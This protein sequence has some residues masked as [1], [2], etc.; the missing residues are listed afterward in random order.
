MN[1]RRLRLVWILSLILFAGLSFIPATYAQNSTIYW[2]PVEQNINQGLTRFLERSFAEA[3][4]VNAS[5]IVIEMDTLGGEVDSALEIGR[6]IRESPIPVAV[7]VK[8][9]A[10]S[11]GAYISLNAEKIFMAPGSAIGAAEPRFAGT[12]TDPKLIA[13]WGSHM[14][15]AAELHGRNPDIAMGMV[16]RN[17]EIPGLKKKGD[18]IS[19]SAEQA[20]QHKMADQIVNNRSDIQQALGLADAQMVEAQL[21][22]ADYIARFVTSP[23]VMPVLLTIGLIGLGIELLSPGF[24]APGLIGLAAFGFYFFGHYLAGLSGWGAPALFILGVIFLILEF[25]VPSFGILGIL[26]FTS[27]VVG[28]VTAASSLWLGLLSLAIGFVITVIVLWI[29]VKFF[30]MKPSW[31]KLILQNEQKN[32]EGFISSKDRRELLGQIGVTTTPLRPSGFAQFGDRRE[33]VI[34]QGESIPGGAKVKVIHVEG[35]RVVVRQVEEV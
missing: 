29:L 18:L 20:V 23:Y 9:G 33:D 24:G 6:L 8:G 12:Q 26:G 30:G 25:F 1:L 27:V 19:L 34:S 32:E 5:A 21:N 15:S 31:N 17:T 10:I 7:Y 4:N 13:F 28:I 11:A 35:T 22:W 14:R 16:D 2:V 3:Q